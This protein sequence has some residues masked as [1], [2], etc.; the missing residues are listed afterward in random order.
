MARL[1]PAAPADRLLLIEVVLVLL[2]IA[3]A[4]GLFLIPVAQPQFLPDW[5][6][7]ILLAILFFAVVVIDTLR[8]RGRAGAALHGVLDRA[9]DESSADPEA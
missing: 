9:A 5:W 8:R 4:I 3:F 1:I 7:G 6:A 2:L